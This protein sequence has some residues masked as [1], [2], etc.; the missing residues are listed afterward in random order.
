MAGVTNVIT[1]RSEGRPP[2]PFDDTAQFCITVDPKDIGK[3][4]SVVC[5]QSATGVGRLH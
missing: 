4:F 1:V 3:S 5:H 2:F